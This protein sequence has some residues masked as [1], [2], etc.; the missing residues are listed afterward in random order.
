MITYFKDDFDKAIRAIK[1]AY[2]KYKKRSY[3]FLID[4][5]T[6]IITGIMGQN[7]SIDFPL[8]YKVSALEANDYTADFTLRIDKKTFEAIISNQ[9]RV[10]SLD[11]NNLANTITDEH[12]KALFEN[13]TENVK[14]KPDTSI[15]GAGIKH[16]YRKYFLTVR[17]TVYL[18]FKNPQAL[19]YIIR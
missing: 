9:F 16:L 17:P 5:N 4:S 19:T 18:D 8:I 6:T 1:D 13:I 11:K 14:N 15:H 7:I 3:H 2:H 10:K 12:V